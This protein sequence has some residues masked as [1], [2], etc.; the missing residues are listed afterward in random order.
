MLADNAGRG[1]DVPARFVKSSLPSQVIEQITFSV[2][3]ASFILM[4]LTKTLNKPQKNEQ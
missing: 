3:F 2:V 4:D 1:A